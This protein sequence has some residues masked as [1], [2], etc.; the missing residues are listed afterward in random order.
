MTSITE[1]QLNEILLQNMSMR[2][3]LQRI[4]KWDLPTFKSNDGTTEV[5]Y[6]SMRGS[7]GARDFVKNIAKEA[8]NYA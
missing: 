8:L 6:E 5:S 1:E 7:N 2:K 3:A 4:A